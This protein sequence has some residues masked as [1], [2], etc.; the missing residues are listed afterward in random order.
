MSLS[1]NGHVAL[2]TGCGRLKG[3]GR[4]IAL[5]LARAG[6]DV[7]ITDILTSGT[8]N[9]SETDEAERAAG[10]T[11]L[12]SMVAEIEALGRRAVALTGDVGE[13]E[14]AERMVA[15]TV[16]RLGRVD[17]LVN[18][19]G[20][21]HGLDRGL[22][23]K[24]PVSSFDEVMRVNTR[25]VFLMSRPTIRHLLA[26][27]AAGEDISGRIVN[28]A[29]G[30][31]KRGVPER[32]AYCASKFG[33]LGLTQVMAQEL[34]AEDITVNA[35]CPGAIATARQASRVARLSEAQV[36]FDYIKPAVSRTGTAE[37]IARTVLFLAEPAASLITGQAINVD[38]GMLM[39]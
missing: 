37:D 5:A 36:K 4:A 19:A 28:I 10:W 20:A 3:I 1:L 38:G 15:D 39:S 34:G 33:V 32:A 12:G 16:A 29:S 13:E 2:V 6:A 8:R 7:A 26:R 18:N 25:G 14:D 17:I 30:A 11:G 31:G 21:P 9:P 24:I 22:T 23:W 35:I 27:R